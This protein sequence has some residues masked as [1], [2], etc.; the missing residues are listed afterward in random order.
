MN[1]DQTNN[2]ED[3]LQKIMEQAIDFAIEKD[4]AYV[5]TEHLLGA[6][7]LDDN[8]KKVLIKASNNE[9]V[10]SDITNIIVTYLDTDGEI[11]ETTSQ[12]ARP[13]PVDAVKSVL[14][15]AVARAKTQGESINLVDA[16]IS[17]ALE[18]ETMAQYAI[19]SSNITVESIEDAADVLGLSGHGVDDVN[20]NEPESR[21]YLRKFC[22]FLNEKARRGRIDDLIGRS[23]VIEQIVETLNRRSK[24][25][26]IIVGD[27]GVGKTAIVEGFAKRV[28]SGNVPELMKNSNVWSLD[29]GRLMAGTRYRGDVEERVVGILKALEEEVDPVLF[30]D[31]IHMIMG[32]GKSSE[33]GADVSNLLKPALARGGLRVIGSTTDAE[34]RKDFEKD[35][36]IIRRFNKIEIYEPS[37]KEAIDILKGTIKEFEK[38]HGVVYQ[39]NTIEEAVNLSV[40]YMPSKVL[41]DKAFD[42][43][44]IAG[45]RMKLLNSDPDRK[46]KVSKTTIEEVVSHISGVPVSKMTEEESVQLDNLEGDLERSVFDQKEAIDELCSAIYLSRAGLR[47]SDKTS[48]SFLFVGPTGVGKTEICKALSK[49]LGLELVKFDMS[50]YMEPH[51][52]SK[53]IGTPPG[54]VGFDDPKIGDGKLINEA[55]K[56]PYSIFLFDEIEKAHP[57]IYQIFLQIMDDGKVTSSSGK[58]ASFQNIIIIMTSNAG[59]SEMNRSTIGFG[60]SNGVNMAAID[61]AVERTF[62]PEFRNRLDSVVKFQPLSEKAMEKIVDKFISNLNILSKEK[63]VTIEL[64]TEAREWLCKNGYDPK[65]GARPMNHLINK[66]ISRPLSKLMLF[67]DLKSGGIAYIDVIDDKLVI[68]KKENVG[69]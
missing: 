35:K 2:G 22:D 36:A 40:R 28:I 47:P 16:L 65:M 20:P 56:H 27:P 31:E 6:L 17:I 15:R 58:V 3:R 62:T 30:I 29:V 53:L 12:K 5:T 66:E 23:G 52:I 9:N 7:M 64:S 13:L 25:N 34:Y 68:S 11:P 41:P 18:D 19:L 54:Y 14:D 61:K 33:G 55:E 49:T 1:E 50:E 21:Q 69:G 46:P 43:I 45:A 26:V 51:S 57:A 48:G 4:Q 67:G 32:A 44:D 38:F 10:C 39:K 8:I 24:N 60:S 59:A 37:V 42:V 63:N